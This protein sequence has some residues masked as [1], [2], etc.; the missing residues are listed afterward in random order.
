MRKINHVAVI[1]AAVAHFLLGAVWFTLL[2]DQWIAGVGKT[3]QQLMQAGNVAMAYCAAFVCNLLIAYT[4]G[5]LYLRLNC[6][7][8]AEGIKLAVIVWVGLVLSTMAT[9]LVFEAAS[10]RFISIVAGYP[11]VGMVI[12]GAIIGA[13][14]A[15]GNSTA[16]A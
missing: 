14:P 13:W 16:S 1:V 15:K 7:G 2:K 3:E 9:E 5:Y 10:L 12:M 6:R 4:I 8:V 11:L